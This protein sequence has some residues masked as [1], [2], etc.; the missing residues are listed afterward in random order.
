MIGPM[1][2]IVIQLQEPCERLG[3]DLREIRK[4]KVIFQLTELPD[5]IAADEVGRG[6]RHFF[7]LAMGTSLSRRART[8][9]DRQ[10]LF[11]ARGEVTRAM[12]AHAFR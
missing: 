9:Q 8:P 6:R 11:A 10:T 4:L 5:T 2:G 7:S 1:P 3:L 12:K